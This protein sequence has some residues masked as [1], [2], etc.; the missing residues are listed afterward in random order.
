MKKERTPIFKEVKTLL[1]YFKKY[2]WYYIAGVFALLI[3]SGGQ[4][5]I[6]QFIRVA[7]DTIET[8]DFLL[9]TVAF[10][11]LGLLGT[12][13]VI[14]V[15]RFGW[16]HFLFG[17]SR[18]IEKELREELFTHLLTLSSAF[19]GRN[20]TGD[21]MARATN[22][23]R[24][25]RMGTG[26][27]LVA[28]IDGIFMTIAILIILF[29]QNA[30][31]ALFTILPLPIIIVMVIGVGNLIGGLFKKVQEG[32]SAL[33][34]QARE[35]VSGIRVIKT[36]VKEHYFLARFNEAN[37]DYKNKNMA[38]IRIYGLFMP[39]ITFLSGLTL[40]LLLRFGGELVIVNR[41]SA[42]EFVATL[43]YL[44]LLTWPMIGVGFTINMLARGAAS[45]GRINQ[46]LNEKP[47]I[48][49]LP[50]AVKS[51]N[52]RSIEIKDLTF[53]HPGM[54]SEVLQNISM[55]IPEGSFIGI[56]GK[57]GSGKSTLIKLLIRL[58]DP[59]SGTIFLGGTDIKSYD[60]HVYREQFGVVPQ[61]TY[62][63]SATVTENIGYALKNTDEDLIRRISTI[64]TID[65]DV[66]DFPDQWDTEIGEKGVTLSGGQKQR[67]AISRALAVDPNILVF[68]DALSAVDTE[69]EENILGELLEYRKGKTNIVISHR[70]S[71]LK[72]ADIIF[73]LQDGKITQAGNHECLIREDGF[74]R[75]IY[76]LQKLEEETIEMGPDTR[77]GACER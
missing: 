44:Q 1:P 11:M 5:L 63:F 34:E 45:L 40:L 65:K 46:I 2:R 23:M 3:T 50:N 69:S 27:A 9:R 13:V 73:V 55:K 15:A 48:T 8:G 60:L 35:S 52:N 33:S 74:Y 18:R 64:S 24:A 70:V 66:S 12:A 77:S 43:N 62:L 72:R 71:T 32:F 61:D 38:Y 56:L 4:L 41:I 42:G 6:P 16:R 75:E 17:A 67:V 20:T 57:T 53:S 36:F 14:A 59:P 76:N 31:L 58:L 37:E 49:S 68:D 54:E 26:M 39:I 21:I 19:Y 25:I 51:V 7:I 29:S 10:T 22:D 28:F 47:E 30:R